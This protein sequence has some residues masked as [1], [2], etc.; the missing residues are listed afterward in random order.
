MSPQNYEALCVQI[1]ETNQFIEGLASRTQL[2]CRKIREKYKEMY[3]EDLVQGLGSRTRSQRNETRISGETCAGLCMLVLNPH[4]RDAVTAKDA[5]DQQSGVNYKPLLEVFVGRK[6]SH[7]LLIQQAYQKKFKRQLDHD[8]ISIEPSHPYQRILM[9]LAA[10]HKS[11]HADVSQHIAKCDAQRLYQTGEGRLGALDEAVVLEILSK[12]SLAQFKLTFSS[13]KKI[14]GHDYTKS[15]KNENHGGFEDAFKEV[16]S[17]ICNP[18][19]YYAKA[20]YGSIQGTGMDKGA[21]ARVMVSR[22]EIDMDQIQAI[23]EN[24]YGIKLKDAITE[25]TLPEDYKELLIALDNKTGT[26]SCK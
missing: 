25:S 18:P 2:E 13:Y 4:E 21:L 6:S 20:L 22:A 19:K 16:V 24:K 17:H 3:G 23:F 8:I 11:H 12:R 15:L 7:F 10:S 1:H 26:T 5:I 9:A 14:Y